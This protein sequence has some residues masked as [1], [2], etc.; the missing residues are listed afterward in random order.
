MKYLLDTNICVHFLRGKFN[1][2]QKLRAVGIENCAISEITVLELEYG[3]ENSDVSFQPNQR[4][5]LENFIKTFN[6]RILPIRP[7]FSVYAKQRVRLRKLGTPISDFDL[8]I[9]STA[10][11]YNSIMVTDNVK[12]FNRIE[13]IKIENWVAR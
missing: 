8:L 5:A 9:G 6:N 2:D 10:L 3:I 4:M 1:L 13:N 7:C 12:E 11:T